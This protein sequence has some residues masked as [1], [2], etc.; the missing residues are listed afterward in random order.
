MGTRWS[1]G[2]LLFHML[3]GYGLV[4]SLLPLV[5]A[6]AGSPRATAGPSPAYSTPA[7]RPFHVVNYLG[8]CAGATVL[9]GQRL[10]SKV[11]RTI[12]ALHRHLDAET[13]T[14][15]ACSMYFPTGWDPY[16]ADTM[17]VL[18]V[19]HYATQHFDHHRAQL[20][21][22]PIDLT[23]GRLVRRL[24]PCH[25]R[26]SRRAW[27]TLPFVP[28]EKVPVGCRR[29]RES[30]GGDEVRPD[31]LGSRRRSDVGSQEA[32]FYVTL[33]TIGYMVSRGLAKSGAAGN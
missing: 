33:L 14:S 17:T 24:R 22:P 25:L 16:F 11:D 27:V 19:Y 29:R 21:L 7:G 9:H 1:I 32:W 8:A 3:L 5:H 15:L 23:A 20:T 18:E 31:R 28:E 30:G 13:R 10:S 6:L 26:G 4:R 2:Q 12:D